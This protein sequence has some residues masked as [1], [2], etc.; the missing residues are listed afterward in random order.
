M[1]AYLLRR[2]LLIPVTLLGVTLIVFA[3]TRILPGGPYEQ[4]LQRAASGEGARSRLSGSSGGSSLTPDQKEQ[5]RMQFSMNDG[6]L[7]GYLKWLGLLPREVNA[8]FVPLGEDNAAPLV[9]LGYASPDGHAFSKKALILD[10]ADPAKPP[11]LE[12]PP[13]ESG[14]PPDWSVRFGLDEKTTPEG[15][16]TFVPDPSRIVAFR[17][18]RS[19]LL[20]GDFQ[21]SLSSG[22]PV[23]S[24]ISRR[25][26]VSLFY[27]LLTTFLTY[28][29]AIPLGVVKAIRHRTFLD[30][31]SS[32]ALFIGY[33]IPG[34]ALGTLL[35]LWFSFRFDWFP[36]SGF[37]SADFAS[38]SLPGKIRDLLH[39]AAL[40]LVC[41]MIGSW[42]L[43]A[44]LMKNSLMDVLATD[45][46]RTA[47]SKGVSFPQ[48]VTRHALRNAI[49]PIASTFGQNVSLILSGSVLIENVFDIPGIG[50]LGFESALHR[51]YTT[52]MALITLS[53]AL[54]MLGN[55]I[56]DLLIA[57]LNPRI[58]FD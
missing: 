41:Y 16:T 26:P 21:E 55:L 34:F 19:G 33:A 9:L 51:D 3:L 29:I 24:L 23:A 7:T 18:K 46:V 39:H 52:M 14:P 53:S 25:L 47:V 35:L 58:R 44:F 54:L 1:R 4:A 17:Q 10:F 57:A 56:S 12:L 49:I 2:L 13:P 20:Q 45:Y 15:H 32:V 36:M 43:Y 28:L 38:L 37:T 42:T 40:P 31:A 6:F 48:A 30:N 22:E 11:R 5:L 27:G 8:R 50:Q